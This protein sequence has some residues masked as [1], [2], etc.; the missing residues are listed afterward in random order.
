[1][2][3]GTQIKFIG[4][5]SLYPFEMNGINIGDEGVIEFIMENNSV[6]VNFFNG[7]HAVIYME[8]IKFID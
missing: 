4:D 3:P 6:S 1:M 5:P 7:E 8:D 2:K